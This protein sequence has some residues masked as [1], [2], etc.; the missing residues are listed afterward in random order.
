MAE[1]ADLEARIGVLE[2]I[3]AIK[4]LKAK[5]WRCLDRKLWDEIADCF[6]QD[7]TAD[8][9][10]EAKG[11]NRKA[12]IQ[13]LERGLGQKTII[14]SNQGHNPEIEITGNTAAEGKWTLHD[15]ILD[16]QT[17][18]VRGGWS[19]YEDEYA[20]ENGRWKIESTVFIRVLNES[21][22]REIQG[23]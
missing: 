15:C 5:Y 21:S 17:N 1:L 23:V 2:D 8:Y 13:L 22:T 9:G 11:T 3:E 19:Y 14:T 4:K 16:T 6:V 18:T 10:P 12:I 20:K 7:A